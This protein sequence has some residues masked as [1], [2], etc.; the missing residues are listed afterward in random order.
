MSLT[1]QERQGIWNA[2]SQCH[3]LFVCMHDMHIKWALHLIKTTTGYPENKLV[4]VETPM[5]KVRAI[6]HMLKFRQ[7]LWM[8]VICQIVLIIPYTI[9][10]SFIFLQMSR[11]VREPCIVGNE[12]RR[13]KEWIHFNQNFQCDFFLFIQQRLVLSSGLTFR[14]LCNICIPYPLDRRSRHLH[15]FSRI[16]RFGN[17]FSLWICTVT[18]TFCVRE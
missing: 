5:R 12:E 16:R 9:S 6:F 11:L 18:I 8:Y 4:R 1:I 3:L 13:K 14:V 7:R 15:V 10:H 2:L 17:S